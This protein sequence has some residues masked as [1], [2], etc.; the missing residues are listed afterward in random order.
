MDRFNALSRGTQLMLAAGVLLLVDTFLNWQKVSAK[1]AGVEIAS[2]S[3]NAWHGF[4]GVLLALLTIALLAWLVA[5]ILGAMPKLPV[6]E[7][8]LSAGLGAAILLCAFLKAITDDFS[9]VWAWIGVVL[10]GLIAAGAWL[11]VQEGGGMET[12]RSE[13]AAFR[14]GTDTPG[15]P[16]Q[17]PPAS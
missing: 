13:T 15:P 7:T 14:G 16:S 1:V 5:A 4:W 2:A 8:L 10:A 6:P 12:L 17:E 11:R 9:T 3:R